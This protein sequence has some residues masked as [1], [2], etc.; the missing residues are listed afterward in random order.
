MGVPVG[1]PVLGRI[2]NVLGDPDDHRGAIDAERWPS[3]VCRLI[4]KC[5]SRRQTP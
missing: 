5:V 3:T 2:M 1:T 4:L